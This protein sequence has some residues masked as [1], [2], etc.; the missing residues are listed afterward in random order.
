[1]E[2]K[3]IITFSKETIQYFRANIGFLCIQRVY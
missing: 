2:D 1:M 3:D